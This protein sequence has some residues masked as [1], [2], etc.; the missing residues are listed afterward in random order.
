VSS[1]KQTAR[2]EQPHHR[3]SPYAHRLTVS[4]HTTPLITTAPLT[5]SS[6]STIHI[7]REYCKGLNVRRKST[8]ARL[9]SRRTIIRSSNPS[10]LRTT[11]IWDRT[12]SVASCGCVLDY[13]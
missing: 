9:S 8:L 7:S 13:P 3:S 12:G 2:C 10:A 6:R 4:Y 1:Q 11:S 5:T